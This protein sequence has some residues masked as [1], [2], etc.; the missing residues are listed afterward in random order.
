MAELNVGVDVS[1]RVLDVVWS[2]EGLPKVVRQFGNDAAGFKR[3]ITALAGQSLARVVMEASGGYETAA[4]NALAAAGLPVVVVNPK[5]V[6]DFAKAC[7]LLAKTDR[8]DA[9]VLSEFGRLLRPPVRPLADKAQ[10]ELTELL[11]RRVQL[12]HMRTQ[13]LN[14]LGTAMPVA[15][16][17]LK[18]HIEWLNERIRQLDIDLTARLR[19][20]SAWKV[21]ADLLTG[22]PGVGKVTLFTLLAR[23]PELGQLSRGRVAA[24]VG[25]APF[26]DDSGTRKGQRFIRGGRTD[27]RNV[28]YMATLTAKTHNPAIRAM[29]KRLEAA[30]KP[31]KLAMT[32]CMRKLL[33]ILNAIVKSNKPWQSSITT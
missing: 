28:L 30:G 25:L 14:R 22:L 23:L 3:L 32:A 27:V 12:V 17:S 6:R 18:E 13:E 2:G 21:K 31:F 24:L 1:K 7:G 4:A 15:R 8:L 26:N 19:S 11:D 20:S 9:W 33:T 10:Q 29:F 5:Q 16:G